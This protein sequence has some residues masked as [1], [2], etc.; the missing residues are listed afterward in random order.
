MDNLE[1]KKFL[2]SELGVMT[3]AQKKGLNPNEEI[4]DELLD[5]LIKKNKKRLLMN[6]TFFISAF[7]LLICALIFVFYTEKTHLFVF[8]FFMILSPQFVLFIFHKEVMDSSKRDL[9]YRLLKKSK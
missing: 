8:N 3:F 9:I 6:R 1:L 4:T 2:I 5:E 7:A